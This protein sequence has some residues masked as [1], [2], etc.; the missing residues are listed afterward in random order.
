MPGPRIV[1]SLLAL[2]A[3]VVGAACADNDNEGK[4]RKERWIERADERCEDE[5]DALN[6]L[7]APDAD[8]FDV[9]LTPDQLAEI[10]TYLEASLRIQDELTGELDDLDLPAEDGDDVEA[11][12]ERREEGAVAVR[13]AIDAAEAGEAERFVRNYRAAATEYSKASQAARD[14]GLT[15]CGQP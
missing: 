1:F 4:L 10:A 12:L 7:E 2:A 3:P 14:F 11:I 9:T 6:E 8:P 15:D 13:L 5:K